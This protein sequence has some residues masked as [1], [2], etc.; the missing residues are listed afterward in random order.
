VKEVNRKSV[1]IATRGSALAL[2]Q[3]GWVK[4]RLE[5]QYPD[6]TVDL[7]VI[8][9]RGDRILDVPLARVG[10]KGLFVKEIEEALLDGRVDLAV[11]SMKD[12]PSELPDGLIMAAV[13]EREDYRDALIAR[14]CGGFEDLP[15]RARVGTSSLRR[16]AQLLH[17]RPDLDIVPLRGNVDTRLKKLVSENLDAILLAAAGLIRMNLRHKATQFLEPEVML[18]AIGQGALGVEI[19]ADDEALKESIA[20][21]N[22]EPTSVCVRAERAYLKRL[23][24]GCQVPIAALGRLEDG[25]VH[26]TGLVADPDGRRYFQHALTAEAGEAETLGR[27]LAETLLDQGA[28]EVLAEVRPGP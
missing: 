13:A 7:K 3:A 1:K 11:H 16:R 8:K 20:F 26:L 6:I 17:L 21:L 22:H 12:M 10:G 28:G 25:R 14:E 15:R 5:K 9:T 27:K 19:R 24:G 4:T 18:P 2:V 23:Q